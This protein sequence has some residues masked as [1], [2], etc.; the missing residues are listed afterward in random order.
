M[1]ELFVKREN[2]LSLWCK[3]ELVIASVN[4]TPKGKNYLRYF[5]SVIWNSLPVE[6]TEDHLILLFVTK[7]NQWKPIVC[8]CTIYK[9]YIGKVGCIKVSDY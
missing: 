3:P 9:R 1:K 5:G 2:T 6:I 8:P 4:S 7:V